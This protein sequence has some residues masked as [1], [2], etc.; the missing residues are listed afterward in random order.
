MISELQGPD[1]GYE[2]QIP[3]MDGRGRWRIDSHSPTLPRKLEASHYGLTDCSMGV[4]W[5]L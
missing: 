5:A 4:I 2:N 3:Q 1:C